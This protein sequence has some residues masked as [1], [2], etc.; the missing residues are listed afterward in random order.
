[1]C[2]DNY[3]IVDKSSE[4]TL[5]MV[6]RVEGQEIANAVATA[7]VINESKKLGI[8]REVFIETLKNALISLHKNE[9]NKVTINNLKEEPPGS[10]Y[11]TASYIFRDFR[12][13]TIGTVWYNL[14]NGKTGPESVPALARNRL[15][16]EVH[17][18]LTKDNEGAE[19]L[20]RSIQ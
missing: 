2:Q 7:E 6:L 5:R 18:L 8:S 17:E 4:D 19:A 12:D 3:E 1:M 11:Y 15:R 10:R 13:I 9:L 20:Q 14:P 16:Y